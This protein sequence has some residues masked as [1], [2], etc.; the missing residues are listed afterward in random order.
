MYPAYFKQAKITLAL[1]K[2]LQS[3]CF[4]SHVPFKSFQKWVNLPITLNRVWSQ[5]WF[6]IHVYVKPQNII[7]KKAVTLLLNPPL[8]SLFSY[9][10]PDCKVER[11]TQ[12]ATL[13]CWVMLIRI[14]KLFICS[15]NWL[16]QL[17]NFYN[18]IF[19]KAA[20]R[21]TSYLPCFGT[22]TNQLILN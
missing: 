1:Q 10:C 4:P 19:I 18:S 11:D 9:W 12:N 2:P 14:F 20:I 6:H 17:N 13:S 16:K 21:S 22:K 7:D 8:C 3:E 15:T 5:L